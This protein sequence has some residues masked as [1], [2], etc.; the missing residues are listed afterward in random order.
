MSKITKGEY[1]ILSCEKK[2]WRADDT[3]SK[4]FMAILEKYIL[5]SSTKE[6][7]DFSEISFPEIVFDTKLIESHGIHF[8][9]CVF[10]GEVRFDSLVLDAE[11]EIQN[12]VFWGAFQM[13]NMHFG[14]E[15]TILDNDFHA[16]SL[17]G[18]L[19]FEDELLFADVRCKEMLVFE[20]LEFLAYADIHN[21]YLEQGCRVNGIQGLSFF[22]WQELVCVYDIPECIWKERE[23]YITEYMKANDIK[24]MTLARELKSL[25]PEASKEVDERLSESGDMWSCYFFLERFADATNRRLRSRAYDEA[26]GQ[27]LFIQKKIKEGDEDIV[28]LLDVA[29]VENLMWGFNAREKKEAW[30]HIPTEI[31]NRYKK[32]WG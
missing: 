17:Y 1:Q 3:C 5:S 31:Q 28:S 25:F 18:N 13:Q 11:M 26:S 30:D 9:N 23:L 29:Y 15:V 20:N 2:G 4:E 12:S 22:D 16:K 32:I 6:R 19:V 21:V 27:L 14:G 24:T 10:Y 7:V 8:F